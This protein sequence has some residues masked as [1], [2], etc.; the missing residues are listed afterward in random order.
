[1]RAELLKDF[2]LIRRFWALILLAVVTIACEIFVGKPIIFVDL[3][4]SYIAPLLVLYDIRTG[5]FSYS[6]ML[7]RKRFYYV[8]SK[9]VIGAVSGLSVAAVRLAVYMIYGKAGGGKLWEEFMHVPFLPEKVILLAATGVLIIFVFS[10][11]TIPSTMTW[12]L[13]GAGISAFAL[14]TFLSIPTLAYQK[15]LF[16]ESN[17]MSREQALIMTAVFLTTAGAAYM[18]SIIISSALSKMYPAQKKSSTIIN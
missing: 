18:I 6:R 16:E 7:P 11:V 13:S 4:I 2:Y 15:H 17:A 1:M 5:W 12:G 10:A 14:A 3:Y 9:Y 8:L